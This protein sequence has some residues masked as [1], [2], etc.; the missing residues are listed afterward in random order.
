MPGPRD[1]EGFPD[2]LRF[3]KARI[4]TTDLARTFRVGMIYGPSGCGKSSLVKAGLLPR[5]KATIRVVYLE[6]I[7]A[8]TETQLLRSLYRACPDLPEQLDLV[9]AIAALRRGR[10]LADGEK[11]LL[12][13]DQFEQWLF[14]RQGEQNPELVTALRQVDGEHVQAIVMVRD[15]FWMAATRFMRDLEIDVLPDRNLAV[16]DR[17]DLKHARRDLAAFG[18]AYGA[19]PPRQAEFSRE[20]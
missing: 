17:F 18:Q 19:L 8:E 20:A 11:I 10:L 6:A 1:R 9:G 5:L 12:V 2:S 15:D 4:E 16:V 13:L 3:W 7:P 14:A